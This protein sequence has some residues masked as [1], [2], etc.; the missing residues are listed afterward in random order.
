MGNPEGFHS[1]VGR[2]RRCKVSLGLVNDDQSEERLH[3]FIHIHR[4]H[5]GWRRTFDTTSQALIDSA[6]TRTVTVAW[7]ARNRVLTK[8]SNP[9]NGSLSSGTVCDTVSKDIGNCG[10]ETYKNLSELMNKIIAQMKK[11]KGKWRTDPNDAIRQRIC[12]TVL[13]T[14]IPG[15]PRLIVSA[16]AADRT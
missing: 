5:P 2:L 7:A 12:G 4:F 1:A 15:A 13:A 10:G 6:I 14:P 3:H 8:V 11:S 9:Q 16:A